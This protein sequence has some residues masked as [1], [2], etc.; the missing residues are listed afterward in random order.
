MIATAS[1]WF[2]GRNASGNRSSSWRPS[3]YSGTCGPG[4]FVTS[5]LNSR[6]EKFRREAWARIVGG[7]SSLTA[8]SVA[9]PTACFD[10]FSPSIARLT[11]RRRGDRIVDVDGQRAAHHRELVAE[12]AP[13]RVGADRHRHERAHL[14]PLGPDPA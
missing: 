5:R 9:A 11:N 10:S 7:A 12:R 13:V 8:V 14:E 2:L 6:V 4:M 3:T 1:A